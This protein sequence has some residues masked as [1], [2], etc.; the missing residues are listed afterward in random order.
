M[1]IKSSFISCT[2][3]HKQP[4]NREVLFSLAYTSHNKN[5]NEVF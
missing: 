2:N 5:I 3:F 1:E 4:V